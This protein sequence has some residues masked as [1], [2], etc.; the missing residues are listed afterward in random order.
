MLIGAKRITIL[1]I[2]SLVFAASCAGPRQSA[3]TAGEHPKPG[4]DSHVK[5]DHLLIKFKIENLPKIR[6]ILDDYCTESQFLFPYHGKPWY[7]CTAKRETTER[8]ATAALEDEPIADIERDAPVHLDKVPNDPMFGPQ[9]LNAAAGTY[10]WALQQASGIDIKAPM[11][12]DTTIGSD[13]VTIA[14]I[15]TGV[16][17]NHPDFYAQKDPAS[18]QADPAQPNNIWTN[19]GETGTDTDGRDKATNGIDDDNNGYIDDV[20]GWNFVNNNNDVSDI[21]DHGTNVA[22]IAA[23]R[24]DN[25]IGIAG[26]AWTSKI[27]PIKASSDSALSS[28]IVSAVYYAI[29]NRANIINASFGSDSYNDAVKDSLA[30]AGDKGILVAASAGNGRRDID[31]R[32]HYPASLRLRNIISVADLAPSGDL[33]R[34]S[35]FGALSVDVAAPGTNILTTAPRNTYEA[36]SGTSMAA[37]QV[38]GLAALTIAAGLAKTQLPPA[39]LAEAEE[40]KERMLNGTASEMLSDPCVVHTG[41]LINAARSIATS[42]PP[43][44]ECDET[45]ASHGLSTLAG[46]GKAGFDESSAINRQINNPQGVA[47]G[48]NGAIYIA[49]AGNNRIRKIAKDGTIQTIAGTG[50]AGYNQ[51]NKPARQAQLDRPAG[52]AVGPDNTIYI[53]DTHNQRIRKIT[54]DGIITTIAGTG[55]RGYNGDNKPATQ[56]QL[57]HPTGVTVGPD[58]TI[59]IADTRNHRI[60]VITP[61]GMISTIAGTDTAGYNED[62]IP[63]TQAKLNTPHGVAIGSDN[64]IYI[65]DTYNNRIRKITPDGSIH[66]IAGTGTLGYNGDNKPATQAQLNAPAGVAVDPDGTLEIADTRNH[67]IRKITPDGTIQTTAGTGIAGYNGNNKPARQAQLNTPVSIAVDADGTIYVADTFNQRIR[68]VARGD[69]S[70]LTGTGMAG[71]N[72]DN[73]PATQAQLNRPNGVAL[74]HNDTTYVADTLNQRIRKI[75]RDGTITTIA[76]TGIAGYNGD[77]K[78]ATQTQLNYPSGVTVGPDNTLYIVDTSNQRIRKI[79]N[80]GTIQ[81][82]AGNGVAGYNGD[83]KPATEANLHTPYSVALNR[84]GTI[85]FTDASNHRLRRINPDGMISTI[86]GT[87]TAGYNGDNKPATQARLD[88]PHGVAIGPDD[89]VYIADTNNQR[90]RKI[91]LEGTI[92]SIAGTGIEGYNRDNKPATQTQLNYPSGVTLA[93][94]GTIFIAD[95]FNSR[96]RMVAPN[97]GTI[98]TI[99]GD[100]QPGYA[101]GQTLAEARVNYPAG[102]SLGPAGQIVIADTNNNRVRSGHLRS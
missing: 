46:T 95:T 49:D 84:D 97:S 9:S 83:N 63:A 7:S 26:V 35:N 54:P 2:A 64:A 32:P 30:K 39:N 55:T 80:D 77:N 21:G 45:S 85:Y 87:G 67:R 53:A 23:A 37:P 88:F 57:R 4:D 78:P 56:A 38:S 91:N 17:I 72:G 40:V 27:M 44:V 52:V 71:Y 15:D 51:D 73:K 92:S 20:H 41:A 98:S 82:V 47:V 31:D 33:S 14:V 50:T 79:A 94:D 1:F 59:Y 69:L 90:I 75:T 11:A 6:R 96:I 18:P 101:R 48:P 8:K 25:N 70:T 60:R 99:I 13:H 89:A 34:T 3:Q 24:G 10:Q 86:A 66:T 19:P 29:A 62:N 58:N 81:T 16:D 100:G 5:T 74:G 76:G 22:G 28:A 42:P 12:W 102:I 93:I 68:S 65:A 61:G 36:S 43:K